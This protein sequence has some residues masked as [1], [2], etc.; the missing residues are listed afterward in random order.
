MAPLPGFFQECLG[1]FSSARICPHL[2]PTSSWPLAH[3]RF[4]FQRAS[5]LHLEKFRCEGY[6]T[7]Q[8][9]LLPRS[10]LSLPNATRT[11]SF[12][13]RNA[14]IFYSSTGKTFPCS[15]VPASSV[16][17]NSPSNDSSMPNSSSRTRLLFLNSAM[18]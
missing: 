18:L 16:S 2:R 12:G 15:S 8:Y 7:L 11:A 3:Q 5:I 4:S 10:E 17:S 14:P 6:A 13:N 1:P 9:G